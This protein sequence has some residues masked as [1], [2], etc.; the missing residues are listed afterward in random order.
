MMRRTSILISLLVPLLATPPA[1]GAVSPERIKRLDRYVQGEV[2]RF[3]LPGLA[4][5]VVDGDEIVHV[6]VFGDGVTEESAFII[7][8]DS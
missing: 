4:M 6:N 8:S 3:H 1:G 7:G 2:S 5:A